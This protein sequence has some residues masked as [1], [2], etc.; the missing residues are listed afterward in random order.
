M[1]TGNSDMTAKTGNSYATGTTT[2]SVEITTETQ[3]FLSEFEES[4][5][6]GCDNVRQPEMACIT[7]AETG[8]TYIS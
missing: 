1:T 4:A 7:A 5:P 8:N 6:S 3:V 2:I